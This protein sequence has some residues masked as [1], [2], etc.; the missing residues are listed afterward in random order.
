MVDGVCL[1]NLQSEM[2]A[3]TKL[4]EHPHPLVSPLDPRLS[5]SLSAGKQTRWRGK[6]TTPQRY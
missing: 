6:E 2:V 4:E 3:S 5:L 1:S